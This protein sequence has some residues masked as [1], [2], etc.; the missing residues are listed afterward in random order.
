MSAGAF[1]MAQ[2]S[3]V[4]PQGPGDTDEVCF[5]SWNPA[6]RPEKSPPESVAGKT[7]STQPPSHQLFSAESQLQHHGSA[8]D[9][10]GLDGELDPAASEDASPR[11]GVFDETQPTDQS[12]IPTKSEAGPTLFETG[13]ISPGPF[14]QLGFAAR[15]NSFPDMDADADETSKQPPH[16]EPDEPDTAARHGDSGRTAVRRQPTAD[17]IDGLA[18]PMRLKRTS[19]AG[20]PDDGYSFFDQMNAQTKPI[21]NPGEAEARFEE[22]MPLVNSSNQSP[23]V[24]TNGHG[25]LDAIFK[26][27]E[28][29]DDAGFFSSKQSADPF[30]PEAP[31]SLNRKSTSQV[32]DSLDTFGN[33]TITDSP[34]DIPAFFTSIQ[35]QQQQGIESTA[36]DEAAQ[37]GAAVVEQSSRVQAPEED[38]EE[39]WKAALGD[40]DLLMDDEDGE[41]LPDN[42][43]GSF[44]SHA[45]DSA[46]APVLSENARQIDS[47]PSSAPVHQMDTAQS[48]HAQ[49]IYTPHQPSS[50]DLVS[51]LPAPSYTPHA[52]HQAPESSEEKPVSF[53]NQPKVGYQSPYDL[54]MDIRPKRTRAAPHPP[55]PPHP[56]QP[57]P[58][59]APAPA[60]SMPPP[61][62]RSSSM[63]GA[64]PQSSSST[65]PPPPASSLSRTPDTASDT[66]PP[67]AGK[68]ASTPRNF[69]EELP[70]S[71]RS[72]PSTRGRYTPQPA[73]PPPQSIETAAPSAYS[74]PEQPTSSP[75][76]PQF[77]QSEGI[78]PSAS[79]PVP[80]PTSVPA[81]PSRYS[82]KPAA[83]QV[84]PKPSAARYSPAPPTQA[85]SPNKYI[86]PP[87]NV[88]SSNNALP[89]QPRTS[90]PLAQHEKDSTAAHQQPGRMD[91]T[92]D[93]QT[94]QGSYA[95]A[96]SDS[97]TQSIPSE[98]NRMENSPINPYFPA[99]PPPSQPTAIGHPGADPHH[100]QQPGAYAASVYSP[101]PQSAPDSH[102]GPPKRSMT[103]SPGKP[104]YAP[105]H[106]TG[107]YEP[108]Q[109]PASVGNTGPPLPSTAT[110]F[111]RTAASNAN[112]TPQLEMVAPTD[113]READVLERWKGAPIFKFGFGGTTLTSFPQYIPRYSAGQ[114]VPK[115]KASTGDVKT[116]QFNESPQSAESTPKFP[117]PLRSK[118]KKKDVISWLSATIASFEEELRSGA[119][120]VEPALQ[121]RHEEK[122][123]L[124]KI[125][126]IMVEHDGALEG[127]TGVENKVRAV[128]STLPDPSE[129]PS[130]VEGP[131]S[132]GF[133]IDAPISGIAQEESKSPLALEQIRSLLLTGGR[134]KA[135]WEAVDHR[136]WGHAMML[137][138][139][140]DQ[141]VWKQV[142]QEFVRREV[143]SAG[144][145]CEPL[146]ALYEIFAGNLDES[147]DELVPVSARAGLQMMSK[148]PGA[149]PAKNTL[150]GLNKWRET[151]T[152]VLSNRSSQ[153]QQALLALSKLLASYGRVEASHI[154]ALFAKS[155]ATPIF[156]GIQDPHSAIVLL[157]AD[158]GHYPSTFMNDRDLWRLSEVYEFATSV[159]AGSPSSVLPHLQS[160]K[161]QEAWSLA[162]EGHRSEAQQYCDAI[163]AIL[164]SATKPSPYYHQTF[165]SALDE[166]SNRLRQAPSDG[167]SSW[168]SKPSIG[169]VSGSVWNTFT[170]F[171][172]GE[173][174]DGASTG[175]AMG[176]DGDTGPFAKMVGTPPMSSSPS[177][178]DSYFTHSQQHT[179]PVSS[180]SRYAPGHQSSSPD[181]SHGRRSMDSQGSPSVSTDGRSYSQRRQSQ[182]PSA[183]LNYPNYQ[184]PSSAMY[185][186]STGQ[187]QQSQLLSPVEE[188]Y[189]SQYS[190]QSVSVSGDSAVR[191]QESFVNTGYQPAYMPPQQEIP[192]VSVAPAQS[193]YEPPSA[194]T[195]GYEPPSYEPPSYEP[196][197]LDSDQE[198][199]KKRSIMAD[200]EGD[201]VGAK[202]DGMRS[203]E[204]ERKNRETAEAVKKAAEE[205]DGM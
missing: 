13:R 129:P 184:M 96:A 180:T 120:Y 126:R 79:L 90:S 8:A 188:A 117:G 81:Q 159:L 205:E 175:S 46:A 145:N 76:T 138:S 110:S 147:I 75:D 24:E 61:P 100:P 83:S 104:D 31:P 30:P 10:S 44:E 36:Q 114:I 87:P 160:F 57:Q 125:V 135:V 56:P 168:I 190:S 43:S 85:G 71:S 161:L 63:L 200:D 131:Q 124:Y 68:P 176:A 80:S 67:A 198:K 4:S 41:L 89:F 108:V 194:T 51:S 50:A 197:P 91:G 150:D 103:Q 86:S 169:K 130:Q 133:G 33:P 162:E 121:Q 170:N 73:P 165:C 65:V 34:T 78:N 12:K 2:T 163:G 5:G 172:T 134:E 128:L 77:Q 136:L 149:G 196:E 70:T 143:R 97:M 109:R 199:P 122:V 187:S 186:M 164:K 203:V 35:E 18:D 105:S 123:L 140:L 157:G 59:P 1:L 116:R 152:L 118:T 182:D 3:V 179:V 202:A 25:S 82:P 191:S 27:D 52:Q 29:V 92:D 201:D 111:P 14:A 9:F 58:A 155:G 119:G 94:F 204:R 102:M 6:S 181:Q 17:S 99:Q 37:G 192:Q 11:E 127:T 144:E 88:Q 23:P 39:M 107:N 171:V 156:G 98:T 32:L 54:P 64:R 146:A 113:G 60:S 19:V 95:R 38:L 166:L 69:Y 173:D 74:P 62:P 151:L 106:P 115:L 49:A 132:G 178:M 153:Y 141:N 189:S 66:A 40:D 93:V 28:A 22:G 139:T 112:S 195:T 137:S 16:D 53:S 20:D 72:R 177:A 101:T 55:H 7:L 183:A 15:T 47:L 167:S 84:G 174:S 42:Q 193:S 21:Y 48:G 154:C 142:S 45:A 26:Q 185:G 158:H 148:N